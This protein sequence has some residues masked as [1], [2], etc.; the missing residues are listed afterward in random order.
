MAKSMTGFGRGT[1]L[2]DGRK[3][4]VELKSVNHRFLDLGFRLP[5][6]ILFL[7]D[8]IREALNSALS[9]GHVDVYAVYEN[10]RSDSRTVELDRPL[11]D[12]Y[13]S[14]AKS[15]ENVLDYDVGVSDFLRVPDVFRVVEAEDDQQA[16]TELCKSAVL[17]AVAEL[18]AMRKKE[19]ERLCR[20]IA[21][22]LDGLAAITAAVEE[23]S[24]LVTKEYAE[25]LSARITEL[26]GSKADIDEQ[27]LALEV[28]VFADKASIT[29]EI[30]RLK[31]H[32]KQAGELIASSDAVG[33]KLDFI[34]QEMNRE[35]NTIGSKASDLEIQNHV[36][37]AKAEI[38]KIR[39][40]VQ[41]IE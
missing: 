26:L 31:S 3:V 33:R 32:I 16:V 10:T 30:V 29:E 15:V 5:R 41:N 23:R 39:E 17:Q 22:R 7:E 35:M 37:N 2:A 40:Q 6:N 11:L 12:A 38:E 19:G 4:S 9:R 13:I 27:R 25:K 21:K 18:S 36:I 1:A 20:D 34:V 14:C 8:V 24:P 28:A